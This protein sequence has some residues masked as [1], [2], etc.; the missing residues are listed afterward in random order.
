VALFAIP[1]VRLRAVSAAIPVSEVRNQPADVPA[2]P[3]SEAFVRTVGINA[4]RVAPPAI[5]ASD[6]CVAAAQHILEQL[7]L[8]PADVGLLVFVTQTPDY[9]LPGNSMLAQQRLG[10]PAATYL[11]DLNQGCAGYVYGLA[12]LAALM[13]GVGAKKGLLLV[14][15]TLTRI[16]SPNDRSTIPIFSDAGSAT[17][18]ERMPGAEPMY[19]N[20]GSDGKGADVIQV[21]GGGTRHPFGP[22]SLLMSEEERDVVRAPIHL[23]MRGMDVLH[24]SSL[25]VASNIKELLAFAGAEPDSPDYY[26]FH[27]ANR[28]LNQ[29]LV[30]RLGI[31]AD[32]APET[33]SEYGNTSCA[34]IPVTICRRLRE[35]LGQG[36][37]KLLLSGF[38]A[39]FSWGSALLQVDSLL[40]PEVI[41][42][43]E[44]RGA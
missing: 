1:D 7:D 8:R 24:Y 37:R 38:G 35:A 26:V 20:L 28:V 5:C 23:A 25:Y 43:D 22:D 36:P 29:S 14:G 15:D 18:L 40:C 12:T 19:F 11:L 34:T 21:K 17:V 27:Q 10:L 32:K 39:G 33:L 13:S 9:P 3:R 16:L 41:E 2:D 44:P 4:R 42:M 31:A 30:K 6:L